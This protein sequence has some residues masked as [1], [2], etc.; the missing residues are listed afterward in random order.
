MA[1]TSR[2]QEEL[3]RKALLTIQT[4]TDLIEIL[5]A[6]C[7][8]RG[9]NDFDEFKKG[10]DE[11]GLNFSSDEI[12]ELFSL[13]DRDHSGQIDFEEFLEKLRPPMRRCRIELVNKAFNKL[14]KNKDGIIEV[15]DLKGVYNVKQHPKYLNGEWSE[16]QI[17]RK[18]LD[19][20]DTR[21]SEDGIITR[22]E[23]LHYYASVS[24]SIDSDA[25]FDLMM[26]TNWKI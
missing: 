18:F 4:S 6:K 16:E 9:A 15:S 22:E 7:L 10:I 24:A 5:R 13:F 20:F 14:D 19:T 2:H 25:Y 21:G 23:F 12:R 1:A 11:Y 8:A 17:L 26:R 3:K